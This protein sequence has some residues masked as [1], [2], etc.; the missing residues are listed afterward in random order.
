MAVDLW[1]VILAAGNGRRLTPVTQGTPKQYW[2]PGGR[3][4]LLDETFARIAPLAPAART[5]VVIDRTHDRYVQAAARPW[6]ADWLLYQPRDRGTAAGVLLA[7]SPVLDAAPDAI[8][9]LTPSD[10]GVADSGS[11][12]AGVRDAVAA[13]SSGEADTVLF[14][15][16][17]LAPV[18]DYGWIEPGQRYHWAGNRP[19]QTVKAFVEKPT[20]DVARR[21][22]VARA[23][24]NTMVVV[25]RASSLLG[26]YRT[27]VA[28]WADAF[29]AHHRLPNH[30]R[31]P[32]LEAHYASLPSAD[33]SRD[34]LTHARGLAVYSWGQSIG[35]SD[36]GTPDRL[37][38]WLEG[39][40]AELSA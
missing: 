34:V 4:S 13:V 2:S 38:Q 22:F 5:T 11:F 37:H 15:V 33:F 16:E 32:F 17:P 40:R 36:L 1:S 7:L 8:V 3:R 28:H 9:L 20:L 10:H 6:P 23:L 39:T 29:A 26:L 31:Q 30:R 14:G 12:R 27:H 18:T 25:T 24:W 19:L 35:W 21:L